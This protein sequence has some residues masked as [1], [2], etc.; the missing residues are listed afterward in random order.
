MALR[1]R[2]RLTP[3]GGRDQIEGWWTDS[4]GQSALKARVAAPPEDGKANTALINLLAGALEV[5]KADVRIASGAA[6]R[7]KTIEVDGDEKQLS[8]RLL[9]IAAR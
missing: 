4:A 3:K 9:Q 7:L 2:V 6:S 1:F 8:V 5:K